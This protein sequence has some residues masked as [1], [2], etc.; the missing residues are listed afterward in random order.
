MPQKTAVLI[1]AAGASTRLG[2]PKQLLGPSGES[3]LEKSLKAALG[4]KNVTCLVMLGAHHEVIGQRLSEYSAHFLVN[5]DWESGMSSSLKKGLKL[6]IDTEDPDQVVLMVCD[7]PYVD[8]T[9]LQKLIDKQQSSKKDIIACTYEDNLGVPSLF[10]RTYFHK[11]LH[12]EGQDGAKK[13]I[14]QEENDRETVDFPEG[15]FDIDTWKDYAK[16]I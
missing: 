7:Q 11:L 2:R 6:L 8:T 4:L 3:L 10:T 15:I 12:L 9:L 13:I 1:L 16:W 14:Y 5:T